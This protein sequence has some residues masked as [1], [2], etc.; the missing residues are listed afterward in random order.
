MR[1]SVSEN[2]ILKA[3][4]A[5]HPVKSSFA[6]L[7]KETGMAR[8]EVEE[9]IVDLK[10]IGYVNVT[11]ANEIYLLKDGQKFLGVDN[12]KSETAPPFIRKPTQAVVNDK[13]LPSVEKETQQVQEAE[14]TP[15]VLLSI[16]DLAK[17]LNKPPVEIADCDLKG[18]ALAKLADLMSD[19]IA[20]LLLAI[21]S[22]LERVAA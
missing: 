22:D 20:E 8:N 5:C 15:S 21:K 2:I 1:I 14:K 4:V 19:D 13:Q 18:Q 12:V 10:K 17:K 7:V 16:D 3:V 9:T 11:P 6:K